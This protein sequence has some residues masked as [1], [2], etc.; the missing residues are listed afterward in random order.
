MKPAVLSHGS[1]DGQGGGL[2]DG[3]E[4]RLNEALIKHGHGQDTSQLRRE[5][6][7]RVRRQRAGAV[8]CSNEQQERGHRSS[9]GRR[10]SREAACLRRTSSCSS[11]LTAALSARQHGERPPCCSRE[12]VQGENSHSIGRDNG[13]NLRAGVP[14]VTNECDESSSGGT[15]TA[16]RRLLRTNYR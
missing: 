7:Q 8:L 9:L 10:L 13:S 4:V 5:N 14:Y 6:W 15:V 12:L 16:G 3:A 11:W 2:R 1:V